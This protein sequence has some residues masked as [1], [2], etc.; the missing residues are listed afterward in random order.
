MEASEQ[1]QQVPQEQT[2]SMSESNMQDQS[3]S[4][5]MDKEPMNMGVKKGIDSKV[6]LM[7][8]AVFAIVILLLAGVVGLLLF[9]K[10]D[11]GI[12]NNDK[13]I[14]DTITP[15]E[16]I[17]PTPIVSEILNLEY[18]PVQQSDSLRPYAIY[19]GTYQDQYV[20]YVSDGEDYEH[21]KLYGDE[22]YDSGVTFDDIDNKAIIFN[23]DRETNF[24]NFK[25]D[26]QRG[27]L[28]VGIYNAKGEDINYQR[29]TYLISFNMDEVSAVFL[30]KRVLDTT[31][32]LVKYDGEVIDTVDY[33][34]AIG[35]E[36]FIN[37]TYIQLR[38][39][40]CSGCDEIGPG[41]VMLLNINTMDEKVIGEVGNIEY[42]LDA[43]T[44]SYDE[45]IYVD[46]EECNPQVGYCF[47][48]FEPIGDPGETELP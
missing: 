24:G 11:S 13:P 7:A 43:M 15:T 17:E 25:I 46:D 20:L 27:L 6:I 4:T 41:T 21:S 8:L 45:I 30:Y 42:D 3:A 35:V 36:D 47:G 34:G 44:V 38:I 40:V 29:E 31:S 22:T 9:N 33:F 12:N 5:N 14:S 37:D 48:S 26:E 28:Y 39:P 19:F 2:S 16:D 32:E 1:P 23:G 18:E 10:E